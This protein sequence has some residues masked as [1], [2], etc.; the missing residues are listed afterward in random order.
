MA[1]M[2]SRHR[3]GKAEPERSMYASAWRKILPRTLAKVSNAFHT[4]PGVAHAARR[5]VLQLRTGTLW[6]RALA[7]KWGLATSDACPLCGGKDGGMHI[8]S[9]CQQHQMRAMITERHNAIG[10]IL[11]RAIAHG[12]RGAHLCMH[13]VGN[14]TKSKGAGL[15]TTEGGRHACTV[16][17]HLLPASTQPTD[18]RT[19][20]P[21][22]LLVGPA[23]ATAGA[24]TPPCPGC[25]DI[26]AS[27]RAITIVEIKTCRDT[28]PS[29][30]ETWAEK[31]H[32]ELHEKLVEAGQC[33]ENITQVQILVGQQATCTLTLSY[34]YSYSYNGWPSASRLLG[35]RDPLIGRRHQKIKIQLSSSLFL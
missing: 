11:M 3:L 33:K 21:D 31:Q 28:D 20:R 34:S 4:D 13:D 16:P 18:I 10:R 24:A 30:Q 6:N 17:P 8:A 5:A 22:G 9:G 25:P 7:H 32:T 29:Q 27:E 15:Q 35:W 14:A 2:A 26:P 23:H 12:S 1:H 19:L